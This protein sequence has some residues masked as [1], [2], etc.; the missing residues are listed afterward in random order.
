[1]THTF[2]RRFIKRT[3]NEA[4][5]FAESII[6]TVREPLIVL[7]NNLRVV[8][9]SRSFYDFFKVK[10]EETVGQFLYDLGNK[11]WNIPKL[12]ELLETILSQKTTFDDYEIEHD[13]AS[14]G[15]RVLLLSARKIK[16]LLGKKLVILL[17]IEDITERKRV[18]DALQ[19]SHAELECRVGER[20]A[21]LTQA[22]DILKADIIERNH[23]KE[24][25]EILLKEV[26]HR[27]KNNLMT[28]I[29]LIKMQ[30]AKA[31]N[32]MFNPMFQELE[33]R[34]RAMAL[35]HE[36]LHK[37][38]SLAR[39]DLQNYIETLS[40]HIRAQFGAQRDIRFSVQAAGVQ[41]D[42]DIAVPCGLILN[43]L[44]T[45]SC[46]HAFPGGKPRA[47]E[48]NCEIAVVVKHEG[49]VLKMNMSDNGIGM[50]VGVDWENPESLGLRLVK[51]LNRQLNGSIELDHSAG[52]VFRLKFPVTVP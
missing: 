45:N 51:M 34:V 17:A 18:E 36:S 40:A 23:S 22:S 31:N 29:G 38:E 16:R 4:N 24:V 50:P 41:V 32:A 26:H 15:R 46:K 33:G 28:I 5:E 12:R 11:Q 20:T 37:S 39:I 42:L 2:T 9:V 30:E 3:A 44:I 14:I 21:E 7:D 52:T 43:E 27:V 25:I 10:P 6:N 48:D 13:F 19:K 35:V 47:G 1:M 49:G 8:K